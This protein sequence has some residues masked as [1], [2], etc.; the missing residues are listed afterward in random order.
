V[1]SRE[2]KYAAWLT[3]QY[4]AGTKPGSLPIVSNIQAIKPLLGLRR[5][6]EY[7]GSQLYQPGD[8]LKSIDWKHSAKYDKLISKEFIEFHGRPD[9]HPY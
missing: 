1:L 9:S 8:S 4:L 7:Y 2:Q 5:G 6:I 3:R